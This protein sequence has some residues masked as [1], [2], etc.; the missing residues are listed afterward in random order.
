MTVLV[1]NLMLLFM[2]PQTLLWLGGIYWAWLKEAEEQ[3]IEA[4]R[5]PEHEALASATAS[6]AEQAEKSAS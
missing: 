4:E 1:E 6:V 2:P 5:A 3:I